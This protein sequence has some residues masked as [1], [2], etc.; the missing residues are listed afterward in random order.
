MKTKKIILLAAILP[1]TGCRVE[2]SDDGYYLEYDDRPQRCEPQSYLKTVM[3]E[4]I[5]T[6]RAK[7]R[8]CGYQTFPSAP[9]LAWNSQLSNAAAAH[10]QDMAKHDY[11][12]HLGTDS[13]RVETRVNNTGYQWQQLGE[14]LGAGYQ[15][16]DNMINIWLNS[17]S[18]CANLMSPNYRE[19]GAAC[20][21]RNQ[22]PSQ[23]TWYWTLVLATHQ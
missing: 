8:Q 9:P 4:R 20:A 19:I 7:P 1:W 23:Y 21:D 5:N 22:L 11:L 17:S 12:A 3:L 16:P 13:S 14:N 10:A 6:A 18:D 2:I 15:S